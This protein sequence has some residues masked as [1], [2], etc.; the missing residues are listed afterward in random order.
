MAHPRILYTHQKEKGRVKW[1]LMRE[2][3]T[4]LL[5]SSVCSINSNCCVFILLFVDSC[6][7]L[8]WCYFLQTVWFLGVCSS[9]ILRLLA[10]LWILYLS[11]F[12]V[13][14]GDCAA[15]Q[16]TPITCHLALGPSLP[17]NVSSYPGL[18]FSQTQVIPLIVS[19][20]VGTGI[21]FCFVLLVTIWG[22]EYYSDSWLCL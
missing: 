18:P 2:S 15:W 13:E 7:F 9:L 4:Y 22:K 17:C 12:V 1:T 21:Y 6:G 20:R 5:S 19:A 14:R 8:S 16:D 3:K 11:S 10:C